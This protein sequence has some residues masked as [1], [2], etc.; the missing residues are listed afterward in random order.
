MGETFEF[1]CHGCGYRAQ[2]SGGIDCGMIVVTET[3]VCENCREL[4]DVDIGFAIPSP[5]KKWDEEWSRC[6]KCHSD[7]LTPWGKD[8]PCP[9]CSAR[10][11]KLGR[12][13]FWD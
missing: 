5:D 12:V 8:R 9:K 4:V 6:P 13:A 7:D 1:K 11:V 3:M 10:M 2:I